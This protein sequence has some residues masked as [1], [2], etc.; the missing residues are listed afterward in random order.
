MGTAKELLAIATDEPTRIQIADLIVTTVRTTKTLPDP[1]E[2]RRKVRGQH[3]LS[4]AITVGEYLDDWLNGRKGLREGTRRSYAGHIALYF[5]PHLGHILLEKLGVTH[6]DRVFDAIDELNEVITQARESADPKLRAKVK[7]RRV[8][9]PATKQRIR[10]T[11]RAALNKAIK[12]RLIDIN[13]ASLVE[14]PSGKAPKALVWTD[15]RI[16]QWESDFATHIQTMNA[17]RK[18]QAKLEPR[19]RIGEKINRLDAYI[20]APRPSRVMVWTPALTKRFLDRARRHRL[21]AQYHLIAF[22][23]LRR[24][25]SCGLRWA[26]LDLAQGTAAIRW[27]ITQIGTDTFEGKPKTAAGEAT[28]SLDSAT[29]KELR[30]HK[31]RQNAERLAA[32]DAWTETGYVFTTPSGEPVD[33]NDVTEQFEQLSME[34]GLPPVRLHDLRHGAATFLL[35]AGYDMKVVQETL[36]LSSIAIA[37][38]IYTSVLPQLARQ[39][40]EDAAAI[41]L[42]AVPHPS[43]QAAGNATGRPKRDRPRCS[44]SS[45]TKAEEH[46]RHSADAADPGNS[47]EAS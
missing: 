21:Y 5:K 25:E 18:R 42:N 16:A 3:D 33:P 14:L 9:G 12:Q 32:G 7:G 40:A 11:L 43:R 37:S 13:V 28:I 1:E 45:G 47:V 39:S 6:V 2:V 24:G 31:A 15:E 38:D 27:Q 10:A 30:A 17:R 35:A 22:R 26:D 34:A 20:G 8:V 4:R 44:A 19:K 23:G 41:V 36:R 29:I 46:R